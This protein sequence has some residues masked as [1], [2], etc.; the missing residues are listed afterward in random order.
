VG[1]AG[2]IVILGTETID[3][4]LQLADFEKGCVNMAGN[5]GDERG[6]LLFAPRLVSFCYQGLV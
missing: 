6:T 4:E 3:I 5:E 2:L 1:R